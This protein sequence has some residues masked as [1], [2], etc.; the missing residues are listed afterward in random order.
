MLEEDLSFWGRDSHS[1]FNTVF[2]Q[3]CLFCFANPAL[4][5]QFSLETLALLCN[6]MLLNCLGKLQISFVHLFNCLP[7]K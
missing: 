1:F 3:V 7:F 2:L 6:L 4:G 5:G